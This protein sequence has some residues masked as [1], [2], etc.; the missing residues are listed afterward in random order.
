MRSVKDKQL[1]KK[2]KDLFKSKIDNKFN[3]E[4]LKLGKIQVFSVNNSL[5]IIKAIASI[6]SISEFFP[7]MSEILFCTKK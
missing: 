5:E 7:Q 1:E 6:Y 2:R 3:T 4:D